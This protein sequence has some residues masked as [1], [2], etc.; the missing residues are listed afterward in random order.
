MW[1]SQFDVIR[2]AQ[3]LQAYPTVK[4]DLIDN[5]TFGTELLKAD[6]DDVVSHPTQVFHHVKTMIDQ[7][8]AK[9]S[10]FKQKYKTFSDFSFSNEKWRND[11]LLFCVTSDRKLN[12]FW[13]MEKWWDT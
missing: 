2:L 4:L 9:M 1:D 11:L 3:R 8:R 5:H 6:N 10:F 7:I 13:V 12:I